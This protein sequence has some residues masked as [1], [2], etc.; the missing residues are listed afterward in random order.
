MVS[1]LAQH[2]SPTVRERHGFSEP[3][4]DNELDGSDVGSAL[5]AFRRSAEKS[6]KT[7]RHG[8][9][10]RFKPATP[11]GEPLKAPTVDE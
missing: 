10:G 1:P 9:A 6:D 4:H 7:S 5:R 3:L 8:V 11:G 2:W